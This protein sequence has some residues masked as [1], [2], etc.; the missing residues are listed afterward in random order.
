MICRLIVCPS[1]I[2]IDFILTIFISQIRVFSNLSYVMKI[3]TYI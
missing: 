1:V 3:P 2:V